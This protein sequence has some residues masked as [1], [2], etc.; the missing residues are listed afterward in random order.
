MVTKHS[1]YTTHPTL[2]SFKA[3]RPRGHPL[4][5]SITNEIAVH[6]RFKKRRGIIVSDAD[7]YSHLRGIALLST[8]PSTPA[9]TRLSSLLKQLL[10]LVS[11]IQRST[12]QSPRHHLSSSHK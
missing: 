8:V 9:L 11:L 5:K 2:P 1:I 12:S 10:L 6:K 3:A 4:W 7:A